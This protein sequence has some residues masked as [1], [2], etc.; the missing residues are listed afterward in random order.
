MLNIRY[1]ISN[2]ITH[3]E[4]IQHFKYYVVILGQYIVSTNVGTILTMLLNKYNKQ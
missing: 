1:I 2:I 4:F 3:F